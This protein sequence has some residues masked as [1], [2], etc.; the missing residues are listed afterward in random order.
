MKM[1]GSKFQQDVHLGRL[2]V[3][4]D[5]PSIAWQ[6]R[7]ILERT[8]TPSLDKR[9]TAICSLS[10]TSLRRQLVTAYGLLQLS[11]NLTIS[12]LECNHSR[13]FTVTSLGT[14]A[15]APSC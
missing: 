2:T 1:L 4:R 6:I 3:G 15:A 12:T 13:I 5:A 11:R 7:A 10:A 14:V 8:R 9:L